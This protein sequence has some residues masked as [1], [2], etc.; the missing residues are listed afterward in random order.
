MQND[1]DGINEEGK[2]YK[3]GQYF[4][5]KFDFSIIES[6]PDLAEAN[7]NLIRALNSSFRD[8]YQTYATYLDEDVTSLYGNID[9]QS[10]IESLR[11]CNRLVQRAL[12][13]A[14]KKTRNL[15]VFKGSTCSL[16]SMTLSL[17]TI[18]KHLILPNHTRLLGMAPQ[19]D[20]L[21]NL[22]GLW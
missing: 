1:I 13:L 18:S 5:L 12:S 16:T 19:S 10:P 11:N 3:P 15:T 2:K 7:R 4:V 20:S 6:S 21:L 22:S 9:S 8:F 17:I 14:R